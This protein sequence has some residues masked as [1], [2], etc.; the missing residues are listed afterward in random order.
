MS[1]SSILMSEGLL[2]W[3]TA[4][5]GVRRG[6]MTPT[7]VSDLAVA[8]IVEASGE[9]DSDVAELTSATGLPLVDLED[10][11]VSLVER[12]PVVE[13]ETA[14]RRWL[15]A[16]LIDVDGAELDEETTLARLQNIYAEFGFPEEL[17]YVSPYNLTFDEWASEP[18]VGNA[19]SA[20]L[21]WFR[22]SVHELRAS[23]APR[24]QDE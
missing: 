19:M 11:L 2:D 1:V 24:G 7:D 12:C 21:E 18:H 14:V 3:P 13:E 23:L 8:R 9:I 20:P 10:H 22:R 15:L 5:V 4:L 16:T 6:W 17:R